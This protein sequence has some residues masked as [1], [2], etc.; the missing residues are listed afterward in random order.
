ME[1]MSPKYTLFIIILIS[2]AKRCLVY[3]HMSYLLIGKLDINFIHVD[4]FICRYIIYV[5]YFFCRHCC[6]LQV[7]RLSA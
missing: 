5:E 3:V 6:A 4:I 7:R 1:R 2:K